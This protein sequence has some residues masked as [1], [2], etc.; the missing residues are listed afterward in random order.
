MVHELLVGF[1]AW[2]VERI[3]PQKLGGAVAAQH[4]EVE[5]RSHV[6][7]I[8]APNLY[9]RTGKDRCVCLQH[10]MKA[11][12]VDIPEIRSIEIGEA[13][14]DI[15]AAEDEMVVRSGLCYIE[16]GLHELVRA[17]LDI[18]AKAMELL[19]VAG[20]GREEAP[21]LLSFG[22]PE[23]LLPPEAE[24]GKPWLEGGKKLDGEPRSSGERAQMRIAQCRICV[25]GQTA[26]LRF[27]STRYF[28]QRIDIDAGI[29]ERQEM[30][31]S[32]RRIAPADIRREGRERVAFI[33]AEPLEIG[34]WGAVAD[35][36]LC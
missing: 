4:E 12:L 18:L 26:Q 25:V 14:R 22:L 20:T 15:A 5:E 1:D 19:R 28:H 27:L 32:E 6:L 3:D 30:S 17:I 21:A 29:G 8:E 31:G 24:I 2:L 16:E 7:L 33:L 23:Q 13:V 36:A 9:G 10:G 11:R 35:D 34:S